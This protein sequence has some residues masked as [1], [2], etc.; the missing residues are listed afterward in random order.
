MASLRER[1]P[2][3]AEAIDHLREVFGVAL[4]NAQIRS[5]M[6]SKPGIYAEELVNGEL[7][8]FGVKPQQMK[9]FPACFLDGRPMVEIVKRGK[10]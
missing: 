10:K 4:V 3:T 1:M 6:A 9:V 2:D 8:T 7:L 5:S